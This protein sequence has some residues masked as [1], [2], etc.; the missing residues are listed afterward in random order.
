LGFPAKLI[1]KLQKLLFVFL[2]C[3]FAAAA[4]Y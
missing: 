4:G 2:F 3:N 1:S